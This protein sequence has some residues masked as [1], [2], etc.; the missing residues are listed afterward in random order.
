[1]VTPLRRRPL[2]T[3]LAI[4]VALALSACADDGPLE[5]PL[6]ERSA[7]ELLAPT[8]LAYEEGGALP[9]RSGGPMLAPGDNVLQITAGISQP[10]AINTGIAFDGTN[11]IMSCW[12]NP[13]LDII[14]PLTGALLN[15]VTVAG[16]DGFGALAWNRNTGTLWAC[17]TGG[18]AGFMDQ[19]VEID[20]TTGSVIGSF[21]V[22]R[23]CT[24]GLAY[25][26][27]DN[28]LWTSGDVYLDLHEYD[29]T[30]VEVSTVNI[31]G[32]IGT[33]NSGIAVGAGSL[34][35][36]NNG[37]Q[38]VWEVDRAF[39]TYSL[40]AS[41]PRRIE[42]LECDDVT[43]APQFAVIWQQDAYDRIVNAFEIPA[44]AC[45]FGGGGG[46]TAIDIDLKPGSWPNSLNID[47]NMGRTAVAVLGSEDFDPAIL[48]PTTI[49]FGNDDGDDTP[50]AQRRNGTLF[51]SMEDVNDDG[52]ADLVVHFEVQALVDNGDLDSSTEFLVLNAMDYDGG[53][54]AG[55]DAVRVVE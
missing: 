3:Y 13:G 7:A 16:Y 12:S 17:G 33:G 28:T 20:M 38:Q 19:A 11:L 42:D 25:D 15:T 30:G 9:T 36:A 44:G 43:F 47:G 31:G 55:E 54:Y 46:A 52:F 32:N 10:C 27:V 34:F 39:T 45:P 35:L 22:P 37:L 23:T 49:T 4:V 1:M 26:G 48:D 6:E 5:A 41:F 53:A 18:V 21:P 8:Y 24:D 2:G 50:V 29:L 51:A 14:D 40:F